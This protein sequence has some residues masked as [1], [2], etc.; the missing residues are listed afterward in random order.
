MANDLREALEE[1]ASESAPSNPAPDLWRR[2]KRQRRRQ[3]AGGVVVAVGLFLA[4]GGVVLG[5]DASRAAAPPVADVPDSA[6]RLPDRVF[7]QS[8]WTKGAA[9]VGPIAVAYSASRGTWSG[10]EHG[11]M[12]ISAVDGGY[13]FIDVPGLD[14]LE[15]LEGE[16]ALSPG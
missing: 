15:G 1:I 3:V 12:T 9:V 11:I 7:N 8:E 16:W 13:R 14:R 6:L 10:G 2:G 5:L 4:S